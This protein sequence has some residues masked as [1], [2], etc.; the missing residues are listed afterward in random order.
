MQFSTTGSTTSTSAYSSAGLSGLASGLDTESM[1]KA[2]LSGTQSK[3]DKQNALHQQ[4]EWKQDIYR[5]IISQ[6]NT[7]QTS[8]FGTS[9]STSLC[10]RQMISLVRARLPTFCVVTSPS[11]IQS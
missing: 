9:S 11:W 2:L 1:V 5:D 3:I 4:T 10:G 6:I 8:Y 7:F